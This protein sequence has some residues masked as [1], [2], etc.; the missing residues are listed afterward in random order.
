MKK[1]LPILMFLAL[2]IESH[3]EP[4]E[5]KRTGINVHTTSYVASYFFQCTNSN[6]QSFKTWI[7]DLTPVK[8]VR[9]KLTE[10]PKNAATLTRE[11]LIVP[12]ED[13]DLLS[14][15]ATISE[16]LENYISLTTGINR[17]DY[18]EHFEKM[19]EYELLSYVIDNDCTKKASEDPDA[20]FFTSAKLRSEQVRKPNFEKP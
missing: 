10:Y 13:N 3:A 1:S 9:V 16:I 19:Y 6:D 18:S 12:E 11:V 8:S 15:Y 14:A 17:Y 7:H 5:C 2:V 20:C 4:L